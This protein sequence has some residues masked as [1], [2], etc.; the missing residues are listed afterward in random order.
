MKS[1]DRELRTAPDL[2]PT[3]TASPSVATALLQQFIAC[4]EQTVQLTASLTPEDCG[5]QAM[6]DTSPPKW[7]LA[8]TSWFF[9]TFVLAPFQAG[10]KPHHP[11]YNHIFNSY[12]VGEGQAFTRAKRGLLSRP[13]LSEVGAYRIWVNE[14]ISAFLSR[15]LAAI[16]PESLARIQLGLHHERQHQ[17]LLLTDIK[18]SLFQNPLL[19]RIFPSRPATRQGAAAAVPPLGWV[20]YAAKLCQIGQDRPLE[21]IRTPADLESFAY[22]NESPRHQVYR[23]EVALAD[24]L[25]TNGEFLAFMADG[26]YQRPE[27]WLSE[28]FYYTQDQR[29]T[30]PLYWLSESQ[31]DGDGLAETPGPATA[32]DRWYRYGLH[33]LEPLDMDSPVSHISYFEADAF[34]R[35]H[36]SRLPTEQEWETAVCSQPVAGNL[37]QPGAVTEPMPVSSQHVL[38]EHP[39]A[40]PAPLNG[41]GLSQAY[42]DVWEW[43]SSSYSPYPGYQAAKGSIGE[44]NGKF[45]VNQYVLKGGSSFTA[46]D[47]IRASYR[48]F[49][50]PP[51]RWQN[52]GLRLAKD[53]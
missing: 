45:M 4:R 6:A 49:F 52:A 25:I 46:A 9:D 39:W 19:P 14:Q 43:T 36:G 20:P 16:P 12:Y 3:S 26:G 15:D 17:E 40:E 47:H 48:N 41:R 21:A 53:P 51:S 28:G 23:P 11:R 44:Y 32:D 37:L 18:Y 22:D 33:G 50:Y 2:G 24:R 8:H 30:A 38:P 34:A 13:T 1:I 10:Y 35:W 29:I 5:L 42:G 27:L 7:H 31:C